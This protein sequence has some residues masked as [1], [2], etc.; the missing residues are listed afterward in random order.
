MPSTESDETTPRALPRG[1]AEA[2]GEEELRPI[3]SEDLCLEI[4]R[5]KLM[6]RDRRFFGWLGE[7]AGLQ[8]SSLAF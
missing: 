5:P 4:M 3:A 7:A 1:G 2:D 8:A 6:P